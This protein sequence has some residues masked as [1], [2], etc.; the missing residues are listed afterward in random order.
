MIGD[1]VTKVYL[2]QELYK[3]VMS[4]SPDWTKGKDIILDR[5]IEPHQFYFTDKDFAYSEGGM[6]D[7]KQFEAMRHV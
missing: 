2:G 1:S 3:E 7:K 4:T 5:E 6:F